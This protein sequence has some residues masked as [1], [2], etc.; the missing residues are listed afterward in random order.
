MHATAAQAP[1]GV[2]ELQT[3]E[4]SA[5]A[6][7]RAARRVRAGMDKVEAAGRRAAAAIASEIIRLEENDSKGQ[8]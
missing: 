8:Q 1:A 6:A 4:K 5:L 2:A 3:A 7:C